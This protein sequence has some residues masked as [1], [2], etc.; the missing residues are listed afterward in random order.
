MNDKIVTFGEILLRLTP[1]GYLKFSQSHTFNATFGGSETNVAVSLAHFGLKSKFVTRLPEND[2]A[3]S[4]LMDLTSHG[5]DTSEVIFGG[6]RM[7]LY[8]F[9]NTVAMRA[10]KVVYDRANSSFS[11]ATPGMY[12]WNRI[13]ADARWFHWSGIGPALSQASADII[14][15]AIT[16]AENAGLTISCDLN[17]RKNL[18]RYG[19]KAEEV[20][21]HLAHRCDILFGTEG[22]YEKAF[23]V[24]P[25]GF[26][27]VKRGQ[28][29]DVDKHIEFCQQVMAKTQKCKKMF[30]AL[31]NVLD[32]NRHVLTGIMY[33]RE[34]K[35]YKSHIYHIKHVVD[36]VGV[37][38]AFAAGMIYGLLNYPNDDQIALDYSVAAATLKNTIQ[39]DYNLVSADEVK[40]LMSGETGSI[41]R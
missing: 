7:G 22:E 19:K 34:G 1:P 33:T 17:F 20:M 32:A 38:D 35:F 15:E 5:V 18:W 9:E 31:R 39:G 6:E 11:M 25:V 29:I 13:F 16:A 8:Y 23:G 30:I 26:D 27:V 4:C 41:R 2:I 40:S 10:T 3:Q 12:D 37:G 21:P 28:Q 14:D 36:C 24:K